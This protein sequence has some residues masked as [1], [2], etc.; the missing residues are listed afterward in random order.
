MT[1]APRRVKLAD[2]WQ[3]KSAKGT[4]YFSGFMGDCQVLLFKEG[5]K[6][7]PTRPDEEVIVWKLLVQERDQNRRPQV[8]KSRDTPRETQP[9]QALLEAAPVK[10]DRS[11]WTTD[12]PWQHDTGDPARPFDDEIPF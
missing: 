8:R 7:H 12:A 3:R 4:V 2:L 10:R 9:G 1:D 5:K 11:E 6:P